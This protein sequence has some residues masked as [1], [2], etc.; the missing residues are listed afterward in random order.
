M[1]MREA[2]VTAGAF[3]GAFIA[4]ALV[5]LGYARAPEL[6]APAVAFGGIFGLSALGGYIAARFAPAPPPARNRRR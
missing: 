2:F 1:N 5:A 6:V 3:V 4:I